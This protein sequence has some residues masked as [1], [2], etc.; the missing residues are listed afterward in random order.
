MDASFMKQQYFDW[1][2][3]VVT[4]N[5]T[6]NTDYNK[7]LNYLFRK[8]F[9][10]VIPMDSNRLEDGINLRYR[11]GRIKWYSQ[12]EIA[13][14]IDNTPCAILE[15]MAALA[16]RCEESIMCDADMGD[17]TSEWFWAMIRSLG[18]EHMYDGCFNENFCNLIIRKFLNR[19]YCPNGKGGLFTVKNPKKDM[20]SIDIW[21]QMNMYLNEYIQ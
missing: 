3:N 13:N 11:Y 2:C 20:R 8:E 4:D 10:Y 9:D 1:I 14:L 5:H 18:L 21:Y 7:L 15:M 12:I 19:E 6:N 16:I 17:R